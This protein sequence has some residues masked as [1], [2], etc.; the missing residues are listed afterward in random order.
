MMPNI[1]IELEIEDISESMVLFEHVG[2]IGDLKMCRTVPLGSPIVYA[3]DGELRYMV[4]IQQ[5][6]Q[7][8]ARE[9]LEG[10]LKQ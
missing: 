4:F 3:L 5:I 2:E 7:A 8:L 9:I 6:Y 1:T 10:S